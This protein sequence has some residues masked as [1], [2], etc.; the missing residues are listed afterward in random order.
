SRR[1]NQRDQPIQGSLHRVIGRQYR[2]HLDLLDAWRHGRRQRERDIAPAALTAQR[3]T[4]AK[5]VVDPDLARRRQVAV[6]FAETFDASP[7]ALARLVEK[8]VVR[9]QSIRQRVIP[10]L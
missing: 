1:R 9:N 5:R 6:Y 4:A 10:A 2:L 3:P 8:E 7:P